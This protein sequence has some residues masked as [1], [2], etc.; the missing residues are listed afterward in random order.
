MTTR[1]AFRA[2][3]RESLNNDTAWPDAS[4]NAWLN[5]AIRD[6]S[7]YFPFQTETS[8]QCIQGQRTYPLSG[9]AGILGILRVEYPT[10]EKPL[11]YL[12][13]RSEAGSFVGLPVY[14]VRGDPP[15]TLVIG[16]EPR[17]SEAIGLSYQAEHAVPTADSSA[18]AIPDQHLDAIK[19]FIQWQAIKELELNQ[20]RDPDHTSLLLNMLGMNAYRAERS[21]RTKLADYKERAAPGGYVGPW[22]VDGFDPVY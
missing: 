4:L 19:L 7:K 15:A 6:Y 12:L 13:Q 20:S 21:Y 9:L 8:V 1:A 2:T 3:L 22:R 5:E 11:R 14:D 16:E 18:L 17:A 10:G